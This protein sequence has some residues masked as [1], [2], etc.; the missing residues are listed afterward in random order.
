MLIS[1][2]LVAVASREFSVTKHAKNSDKD[3]IFIIHFEEELQ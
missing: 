3:N 1:V 2:S